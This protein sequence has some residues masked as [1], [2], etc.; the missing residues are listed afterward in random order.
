MTQKRTNLPERFA[1]KNKCPDKVT[2]HPGRSADRI[3]RIVKIKPL[4]KLAVPERPW[5]PGVR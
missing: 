5:Q 2:T 3:Y 1:E 4:T